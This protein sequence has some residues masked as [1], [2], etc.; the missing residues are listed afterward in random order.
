MKCGVVSAFPGF[1]AICR[2]MLDKEKKY[3]VLFD[4]VKERKEQITS[5]DDIYIHSDALVKALEKY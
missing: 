5:L 4:D 3:I 1:K 2:L